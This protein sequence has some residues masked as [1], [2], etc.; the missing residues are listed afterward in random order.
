MF[1]NINTKCL[2]RGYNYKYDC[3]NYI[4]QTCNYNYNNRIN[5]HNYVT[6]L[7]V[8]LLNKHNYIT[9]LESHIHSLLSRRA[10]AGGLDI[11]RSYC[12]KGLRVKLLPYTVL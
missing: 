4:M 2:M 9:I 6:N 8:L 3:L 11:Y 1:P 5:R 10:I 12:R 7:L